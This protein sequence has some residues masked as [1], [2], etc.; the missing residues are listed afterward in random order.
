VNH[1]FYALGT[2]SITIT[3]IDIIKRK[4]VKELNL[5]TTSPRLVKM[6]PV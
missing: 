4:W 2:L 6:W 1:K 3:V 5:H